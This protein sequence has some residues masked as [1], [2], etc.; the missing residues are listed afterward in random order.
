MGSTPTES[1]RRPLR[2]ARH[3]PH[4][5]WLLGA[6]LGAVVLGAAACGASSAAT[7]T[8]AK[9]ASP[10]L[11]VSTVHSDSLGTILVDQSGLTLYRYTPDGTG[12][13]TCT[14]ACATA[15]PPLVLPTAATHLT[16]KDGV[17]TSQLGTI[18]RPGGAKQVTFKGMPLYR[19]AGD[20]AA[21]QTKGQGVAGAWFVVSTSAAPAT[22]AVA[23]TTTTAAPTTVTTAPPV[24]TTVPAATP[25]PAGPAATP[26]VMT[27]APATT[28]DTMAAPAPAA[29]PTSTQPSTGGAGF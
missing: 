14:G 25:A 11:T 8:T 22:P 28:P 24:A 27:P 3:R 18:T 16:G 26:P 7:T 20:T 23:P 12:K 17:T 15:W 19:F 4:S 21:G 29:A 6:V 9:A 2:S 10:A 1:D 5:R 13:T